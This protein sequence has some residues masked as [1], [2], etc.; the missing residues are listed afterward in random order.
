MLVHTICKNIINYYYNKMKTVSLLKSAFIYSVPVLL[1]YTAIGLAFGLLLSDAGY[2]W[3]LAL[4]MS[5]WMY[6]GAGQYVAV[7]LFV[8]G[9]A[10]LESC[11]IQLVLSARHIAY[12]L[13]MINRFPK[14][15]A[16]PYM[17]FSMTDETFALLSSLPSAAED[18]QAYKEKN[19]Q[20]PRAV[21]HPGK[22]R[23]RFMFYVSLLDHCY[24]IGGSLAG[25]V[26]GSLI[27]FDMDGIGFSLT[28]LFLILFLEQIFN[29]FNISKTPGNK[30]NNPDFSLNKLG[31]FV[32]SAAAALV[33]VIL[34]PG[35]VALLAGMILALLLSSLS[36]ITHSKVLKEKGVKHENICK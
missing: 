9:A 32:L 13:S 19:F 23:E 21:L 29:V 3:F 27:P 15:P 2:P 30:N 35:R 26:I 11:I 18:E 33:S 34:F 10:L 1:G 12:G 22:E 14:G 6:T 31:I 7:G 8:T 25:A 5:L 36:E 28:A 16:K 24:W 4:I 17:I 20:M